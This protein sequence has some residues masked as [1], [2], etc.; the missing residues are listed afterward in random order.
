MHGRHDAQVC[1][2]DAY[3]VDPAWQCTPIALPLSMLWMLFASGPMHALL[4]ALLR[5][6][7]VQPTLHA[8]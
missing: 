8:S 6:D 4:R 3:T 7:D 1:V 2:W 5:I